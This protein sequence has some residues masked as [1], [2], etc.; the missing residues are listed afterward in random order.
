MYVCL[1][2]KRLTGRGFFNIHAHLRQN[3]MKMQ[4]ILQGDGFWV[5]SAKSPHRENGFE[6]HIHS[7]QL[8]SVLVCMFQKFSPCGGFFKTPLPVER[9]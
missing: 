5:S 8:I 2:T 3:V 4:K 7:G 9:F 1:A 6:V